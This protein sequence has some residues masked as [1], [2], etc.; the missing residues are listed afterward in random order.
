LFFSEDGLTLRRPP[1]QTLFRADES[2]LKA[3]RF[4]N[5]SAGVDHKLPASIY[6]RVEVIGRRGSNG[7]AYFDASGDGLAEPAALFELRNARR[8]RFDS[9]QITARRAFRRGYEMMASYTRSSA[10]SNAVFDFNIDSPVFST[11]IEGPLPWDT[12]NRFISWGWLPLVRRFD[13]AYSLEW[14]DGF[15]FSIVNQDQQVV[16]SPNSR[17]LPATFSLNLHVERR[18]EMIGLRWALRAGFNNVTGRDNPTGVNNNIDSREFLTLGGVQ[19]RS[20]TG[21]IR[22]LGRK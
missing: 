20:F 2:R 9:L 17:R 8:D 21:R 12:P 7:L 18:F 14:R 1:L 4:I 5:W 10:R 22:F 16:G 11:Q 6:M 13:F 3:P 19:G 15:P